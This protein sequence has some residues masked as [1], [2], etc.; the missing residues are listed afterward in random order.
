MSNFSSNSLTTNFLIEF[1]NLNK[2]NLLLS[3]QEIIKESKVSKF[4]KF[5]SLNLDFKG[6][7]PFE[8]I[9]QLSLKEQEEIIFGFKSGL[10]LTN[11]NFYLPSGY[12]ARGSDLKLEIKFKYKG[13]FKINELLNIELFSREKSYISKTKV[14]FINYFD[15][16]NLDNFT[17]EENEFILIKNLKKSYKEFLLQIEVKNEEE[18][19]LK[20]KER[21][22]KLNILQTSIINELDKDNNGQIDLVDGDSFN[23]LLNKNQKSIIDLDK[24]YV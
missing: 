4:L 16:D 22:I 10:L 1:Y 20:E 23:K 3:K 15:C 5:I 7:N 8:F 21:K 2:S 12:R 11:E 18:K 17:F 9:N 19:R 13:P 14:Y 24:N 6:V